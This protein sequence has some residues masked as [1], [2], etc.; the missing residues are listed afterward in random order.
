MNGEDLG[1][2]GEVVVDSLKDSLYCELSHSGYS[3]MPM[4]WVVLGI[5]LI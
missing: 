4:S 2:L 5:W 3:S 1:I